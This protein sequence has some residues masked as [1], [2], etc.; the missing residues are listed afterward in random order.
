MA[1]SSEFWAGFCFLFC[2]R[3]IHL[4][5]R[6]TTPTRVPTGKL[7]AAVTCYQTGPSSRVPATLGQPARLH[8]SI[9][10]HLQHPIRPKY[11]RLDHRRALR[12]GDIRRCAVSWLLEHAG[13]ASKHCS[14]TGGARRRGREHLSITQLLRRHLNPSH[15]DAL[16]ACSSEAP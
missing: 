1:Y 15:T 13:S 4:L 12:R 9:P 10:R 14:Q 7:A 11:Q 8:A 16:V 3:K 5:S 2:G 6:G